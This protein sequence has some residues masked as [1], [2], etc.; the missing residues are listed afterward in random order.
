MTDTVNTYYKLVKENVR[1]FNYTNSIEGCFSLFDPM[2]IGIYHY[3]SPRHLQKYADEFTFRYNSRKDTD[4]S[5]FNSLLS[6]C[7]DRLTYSQ[8]T[9]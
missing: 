8:L 6:D 5:R 9:K 4:C 1:G 3:V 2:V 7:T